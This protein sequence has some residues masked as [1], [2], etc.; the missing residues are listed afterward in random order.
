MREEIPCKG[1]GGAVF[2]A[3]HVMDRIACVVLF[4][5]MVLTM[6]DVFG[7]KVFSDSILGT[8]E[9]SEFGLVVLVFFSLAH[10]EFTDGHVRVDLIMMQFGER[11]RAVADTI[12]Q[13]LCFGIS[14]IATCSTF[15]YAQKMR[16]SGEVSQDLWLPKHPFIYLAALGFAVLSLTMLVRFL[17]ACR[18]AVRP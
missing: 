15:S 7:R 1:W 5:L 16:F 2:R 11:A 18:K 3:S 4:A 17:L 14:L 13:F 12:T 8:V 10:T 6:A 9:L